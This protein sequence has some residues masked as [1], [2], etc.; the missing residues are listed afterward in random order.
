[1]NNLQNNQK[2]DAP[3]MGY[4]T[5]LAAV[6]SFGFYED[7]NGGYVHDVYQTKLLKRDDDTFNMQFKMQ[8]GEWCTTFTVYDV[9]GLKRKLTTF[10][11]A[12][13]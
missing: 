9:S 2:S 6:I 4:D 10:C 12:V 1:M 13:L 8:D 7:E 5:L 3:P 11:D